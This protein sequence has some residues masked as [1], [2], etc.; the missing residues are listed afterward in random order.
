[1]KQQE[2]KV[3]KKITLD[4]ESWLGLVD[5]LEIAEKDS[6]EYK[7]KAMLKLYL[8]MLVKNITNFKTMVNHLKRKPSVLGL[9]GFEKCPHRTTLSTRFKVMPEDIRKQLRALHSSFV[10]EE[11]SLVEL[12]STDSSLMEAAGNKWH[13]KDREKGV[14]PSCGN[15]DTDAHWGKSGCGKWTFGYR[16]HCVVS[17]QSTLP[18]DVQVEPAHVKDAYVFKRDFVQHFP[19]ETLVVLGDSGYDDEKCY[20]LCDAQEISLITPIKAKKSTPPERLE[21]VDLY[22]DHDV[23]EIFIHRK[24]S[25]EPFQG[26]LK[27]LFGL[28]KLCMK[29][30]ENVRALVSL[31]TFAYL[32]LAK[33]NSYLELDILKLQDTLLAIR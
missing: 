22:N 2:T 33:F 10:E 16:V 24:T 19:K 5:E 1:M 6:Y 31:A 27:T 14:I 21:R 26:H 23:R 8:Y 28:E 13:K 7:N 18:Y 17:C 25:V 32:L 15:I 9:V 30:I 3:K 4:M 12:M 11:E 29:G 20:Q